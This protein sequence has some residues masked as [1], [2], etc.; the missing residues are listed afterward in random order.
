MAYQGD[1]G[2]LPWRAGGRSDDIKTISSAATGVMPKAGP[3]S[4]FTAA[5]DMDRTL[6]LDGLGGG[7]EAEL[8]FSTASLLTGCSSLE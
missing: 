3:K 4:P 8:I 7:G 6:K 1:P 5:V 2:P